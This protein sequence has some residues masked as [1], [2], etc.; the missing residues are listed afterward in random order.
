MTDVRVNCC[1][2]P[3]MNAINKNFNMDRVFFW[4]RLT[5]FKERPKIWLFD[6]LLGW[7][8][9]D[10]H[11]VELVEYFPFDCLF[12]LIGLSMVKL[13][14]L[15]VLWKKSHVPVMKTWRGFSFSSWP[16]PLP[17]LS[18]CRVSPLWPNLSF[19]TSPSSLIHARE[20]G[21]G[22]IGEEERGFRACWCRLPPSAAAVVR[23]AVLSRMF[24]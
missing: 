14:Y 1:N 8:N 24:G 4:R 15:L 21:R 9:G 5:G 18:I 16:I 10:H 19:A 17:R 6:P 22:R 3:R 7:I 13:C 23:G 2:T 12:A 20:K 11:C